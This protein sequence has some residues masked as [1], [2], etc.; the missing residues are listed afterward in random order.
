MHRLFLTILL[1]FLF[2][3]SIKAQEIIRQK[4]KPELVDSLTKTHLSVS[5]GYG[6]RTAPLNDD[7]TGEAEEHYKALNKGGVLKVN[8]TRFISSTIGPSFRYSHFFTQKTTSDLKTE[9]KLHFFGV[10]ATARL[11]TDAELLVFANSHIG[12]A[13]Y[14]YIDT[15]QQLSAELTGDALGIDGSIGLGIKLSQTTNFIL[16]IGYF[17][18]VL[19]E[20]QDSSGQSYD[21]DSPEGLQRVDFNAGIIINF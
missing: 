18:A 4:N 16:S 5:F 6:I 7:L 8:L 14:I 19:N 11:I 10:G 15:I 17:E 21:L 12:Y 9:T 13:R 2:L 3:P 1:Y 20:V